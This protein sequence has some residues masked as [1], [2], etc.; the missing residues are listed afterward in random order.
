MTDSKNSREIMAEWLQRSLVVLLISATV[1]LVIAQ[2]TDLD[3]TM[4]S[5]YYDPLT[6]KFPWDQTWFGKRLMHGY[7]KNVLVWFGYALIL[8][9]LTDLV[10]SLR[11]TVAQRA[12]IRVLALASVLEPAVV[13]SIKHRSALHCPWGVEDFGGDYPYLRLLSA[14]PQ[15]WH[16]GRC[17]PAGH[18]S[19]AMWLC[20]LAVLWLPHNPR[21]ALMVFLGGLAAGGTLGWVQQMRGQHFFTHTLATAWLSSAVVLILFAAFSRQLCSTESGNTTGP[22][23]RWLKPAFL[24]G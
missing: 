19:A 5:W 8:T 12:R 22:R 4:A 16:G 3:M 20:A 13:L 6:H 18:A 15:G 24:R 10:F 23:R 17:F 7:V 2:Y 14:I 11:L 21:R 1:I 9:A